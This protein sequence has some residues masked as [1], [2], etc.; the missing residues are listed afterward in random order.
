MKNSI[1]TVFLSLICFFGAFGQESFADLPEGTEGIRGTNR[2]INTRP[3]PDMGVD[4]FT[5]AGAFMA[6]C[7]S[8]EGLELTTVMEDFSGTLLAPAAVMG[9]G[10]TVLDSNTADACFPAGGVVPGFSLATTLLGAPPELFGVGAG[11]FGNPNDLF[12]PGFFI[13]DIILSYTV[14]VNVGCFVYAQP[15]DP[16][17][18]PFI[19]EVVGASGVLG[20]FNGTGNG[21]TEV[22]VCFIASEDVT[23]VNII[24]NGAA[25][26]SGVDAAG[27][28]AGLTFGTCVSTCDAVAGTLTGGPFEFCV[29]DGL[30]DTFAPGDLTSM[31]ASATNVV[32]VVTDATNND[33]ILALPPN[34]AAI[35][36]EGVFPGTCNV[37]LLSHEDDLTGLAMGESI[38]DLGGCFALS[39][40]VVVERV[41]CDPPITVIPLSLIHI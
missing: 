38:N 40:P 30:P 15:L 6:A 12:G 11:A 17:G 19:V 5:D 23:T 26:G 7:S 34:Q 32:Y 36:F 37:W 33:N 31:G 21:T 29:T 10:S 20:T 41:E 13:D 22:T 1:L 28:M 18:T 4:F 27:L 35:D 3:I 9:C 25:T 24:D 8:A 2:P 39:N 16:P 14:P